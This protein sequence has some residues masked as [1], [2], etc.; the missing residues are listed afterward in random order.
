MALS[1][2]PPPHTHTH[3][4]TLSLSLSLSIYLSISHTQNVEVEVGETAP[5]NLWSSKPITRGPLRKKWF[6]KERRE[7]DHVTHVG[8]SV[9]TQPS[10]VSSVDSQHH[11]W[12]ESV[13]S[14]LFQR[15]AQPSM[16]S[17]PPPLLLPPP[18]PSLIPPSLSLSLLSLRL[19]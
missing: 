8:S 2:F 9:D 10:V 17:L 6:L 14:L 7:T 16:C 11:L 15:T 4:H 1:H 5:S 12:N 3:T 19:R 18:P 13:W